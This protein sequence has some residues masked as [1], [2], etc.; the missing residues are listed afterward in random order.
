M[1]AGSSMVQRPER[2]KAKMDLLLVSV[3]AGVNEDLP[4]RMN[5]PCQQA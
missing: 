4:Y 3:A 1:L 2:R 5:S